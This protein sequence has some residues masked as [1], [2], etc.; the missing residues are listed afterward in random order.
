[1]HEVVGGAEVADDEEEEDDHVKK[2]EFL[3]DVSRL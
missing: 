3:A 2:S 1:M